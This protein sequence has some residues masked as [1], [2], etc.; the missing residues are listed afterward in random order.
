[1]HPSLLLLP[2]SFLS[3]HAFTQA[4]LSKKRNN[5]QAFDTNTFLHSLSIY[6]SC[7]AVVFN[8]KIPND[9]SC[10][11]LIRLDSYHINAILVIPEE[12]PEWRCIIPSVLQGRC[13]HLMIPYKGVFHILGGI[14]QDPQSRMTINPVTG[15]AEI[16]PSSLERRYGHTGSIIGSHCYIFGGKDF[17][18]R[19][20]ELIDYNMETHSCSLVK[21]SG[22]VPKKRNN[23]VSVVYGDSIIIYGGF[24]KEEGEEGAVGEVLDDMKQFNL[25]TKKWVEI[26]TSDY[27]SI[28]DE[29]GKIYLHCGCVLDD[30]YFYVFGGCHEEVTFSNKDTVSTN[31]LYRFNL[32]TCIWKRLGP[33]KNSTSELGTPSPADLTTGGRN[34]PEPRQD[35]RL[36][37][38]RGTLILYGGSR[39]SIIYTDVW[40]YIPSLNSWICL[41]TQGTGPSQRNL[42]SVALLDDTLYVHGGLR[43]KK[44]FSELYA[45]PLQSCIND[46]VWRLHMILGYPIH[47]PAVAEPTL[48]D[49]VDKKT[50]T[51]QFGS[52]IAK[53]ESIFEPE[54]SDV[55][56]SRMKDYLSK[57]VA[58]ENVDFSFLRKE[59]DALKVPSGKQRA[60]PTSSTTESLYPTLLISKDRFH[61]LLH[62]QDTTAVT[63]LFTPLTPS[64]HQLVKETVVPAQ[65]LEK[66]VTSFEFSLLTLLYDL[67][68]CDAY[69][70]FTHDA[71]GIIQEA[72]PYQLIGLPE[73]PTGQFDAS[74]L[75]HSSLIN[76]RIPQLSP[77]L[78]KRPDQ[79]PF[80]SLHKEYIDWINSAAVKPPEIPLLESLLQ[81]TKE[82]VS[83]REAEMLQ[84][85]P[86]RLTGLSYDAVQ[87]LLGYMCT[88]KILPLSFI[89]ALRNEHALEVIISQTLALHSDE[90][91]RTLRT[92]PFWELTSAQFGIR[93][94]IP[95][96]V[97]SFPETERE[98]LPRTHYLDPE[99]SPT[100]LGPVEC[101]QLHAKGDLWGNKALSQAIYTQFLEI[102][103]PDTIAAILQACST[104]KVAKMEKMFKGWTKMAKDKG[105]LS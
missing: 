61:R 40:Q 54:E 69:L 83:Q 35:A 41:Q 92:E 25:H 74:I 49:T 97:L 55:P 6:D 78:T 98:D 14:G 95:N 76:D 21:P 7:T 59:L 75:V 27:Q 10:F 33:K 13:N 4:H 96:W 19:I 82:L 45:L 11:S 101:A 47:H 89:P 94:G 67:N 71:N 105:I 18:V 87:A 66:G 57:L 8:L 5:E 73:L 65:L 72:L 39:G 100:E 34:W 77:F 2:S 1:M 70:H 86:Q 3:A 68:T 30:N 81:R 50:P 102:T 91:G 36:F 79:T 26:K 85:I 9:A 16:L 15:A 42:P 60:T 104:Y 63:P 44:H 56:E 52:A 103:G 88:D 22:V 90:P 64:L 51:T 62:T 93:E 29:P 20:N 58:S 31:D 43:T 17:S 37:A 84:T 24:D 23:H 48:L 46:T 80:V 38:Y 28:D 53:V 32:Q 12:I 99:F